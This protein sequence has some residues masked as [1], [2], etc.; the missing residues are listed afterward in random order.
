[1]WARRCCTLAKLTD[2]LNHLPPARCLQVC[3]QGYNMLNLL[4]HRKHLNCEFVGVAAPCTS[5]DC[6]L[7]HA[8][9]PAAL[10][11]HVPTHAPC[12]FEPP[13]TC[14]LTTTST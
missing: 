2:P 1:M 7:N 11:S 4:I 12:P 3:R 8:A 13:Q 5:V 9:V 6:P 10:I 14:I